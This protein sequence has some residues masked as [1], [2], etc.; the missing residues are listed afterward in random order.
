MYLTSKVFFTSLSFFL[1]RATGRRSHRKEH[2]GVE[3]TATDRRLSVFFCFFFLFFFPALLLFGSF[4]LSPFR[5]VFRRQVLGR[6]PLPLNLSK[7]SFRAR[8]QH[9]THKQNNRRAVLT[10]SGSRG[11]LFGTGAPTAAPSSFADR[12]FDIDE[13]NNNNNNN[14]AVDREVAAAQ[15]VLLSGGS[16]G[17]VAAVVA[18][19]TLAMAVAGVLS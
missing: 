17:V 7:L 5:A 6:R 12:G 1:E 13:D 10:G 3:T 9:K 15:K 2:L 11:G 16:A 18:T 19:T 14:D 8:H 4:R